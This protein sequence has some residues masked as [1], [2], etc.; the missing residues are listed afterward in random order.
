MF[1]NAE[2]CVPEDTLH[3]FYECELGLELLEM[4]GERALFRFG[5]QVYPCPASE[6]PFAGYFSI[7]QKRIDDPRAYAEAFPQSNSFIPEIEGF[8][9]SRHSARWVASA[10][11][12]IAHF[13]DQ[14]HHELADIAEK[15]S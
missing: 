12:D 6:V 1:T 2:S 7:D 11:T 3:L 5:G 13:V 10:Y 14:V 9:A 4:N 8:D 15:Q